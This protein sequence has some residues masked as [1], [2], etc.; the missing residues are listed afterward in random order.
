MHNHLK[1]I[2]LACMNHEAA[3]GFLPSGG[4]SSHWAGD[5]DRGFDRRQ[6][7]GW[8]YN[9]LPYMELQT[10]HDLGKDG[11]S[12]TGDYDVSKAAGIWLACSTPIVNYYCPS[13]HPA[14]PIVRDTALGSYYCNFTNA[15]YM[16]SSPFLPVVGMNDYAGNSGCAA[17]ASSPYAGGAWPSN[18]M[19]P[20]SLANFDTTY[21]SSPGWA[22]PYQS[23][24][25]QCTGVICAF[26]AFRLR[27]ITD[28]TSCT[29][30]AGEKYV[31]PDAYLNGDNSG[32]NECW[33]EGLDNDVNRITS[34]KSSYGPSMGWGA[35]GQGTGAYWPPM[36]DQP[37]VS[38][39]GT[40]SYLFGGPHP[41]SFNMVFCDGSVQAIPYN[42]NP[43][44]HDYL[45]G[46]NDGVNA[47][48][49]LD[50]NNQY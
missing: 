18:P 12:T 33:D 46:R 28:G 29:Y 41:N 21:W 45:G 31:C 25:C 47:A 34:W 27:D 19:G 42:I 15:G 3:Q 26:G 2:G 11:N 4:W 6:P 40:Y 38:G 30:L 36:Q 32:T 7:G 43:V 50:K 22:V 5:P 35:N 48:I 13:R 37:G 16:T 10:V 24:A 49:F 8:L 14:M 1:Q 17:S 9:I 23:S 20:T 44:I 39:G